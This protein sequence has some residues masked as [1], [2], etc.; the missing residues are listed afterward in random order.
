MTPPTAG[1]SGTPLVKKLGIK[2]GSTVVLAAAPKGFEVI[3][4]TL[5][6][7]S[8][9]VRRPVGNR[10]LTIWFV[11]KRP[12]LE[13]KIDAMVEAMGEGGLWICWP[14]QSS[15]VA[16]DL[17]GGIIRSCGLAAGVVDHKVCALD[18]TWS[19]HRFARR[20]VK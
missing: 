14:K 10:N 5:P 4:G 17:T 12:D 19:G 20:R 15:G 11:R 18:R 16:T 1:Y 3:L 6:D 2:E 7:G 8:R 9:L 13:K